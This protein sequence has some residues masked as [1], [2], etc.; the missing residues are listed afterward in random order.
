MTDFNCNGSFN[1]YTV[2][3]SSDGAL[4]GIISYMRGGEERLEDFFLEAGENMTFSSYIDGFN[5]GK[6]AERYMDV[7]F[8]FI[9]G[10]EK[11]EIFSVETQMAETFPGATC[12]IESDRY[13]LGV[14]LVWG[15]GLSYLEDKRNPDK[16]YDN[17]LNFYDTGRLVQ[18][19]YYG[20]GSYP[21]VTGEFMGNRW[22]Y[23]PVQGGDRG[24]NKSKLI[25]ARITGNSVYVKC[26]PR[27]WG[28]AGGYT[29]SYMENTYTL[30]GDIIRVDNRFTDFSGYT[31]GRSSQEVPAFYTISYLGNFWFYSGDKPW[32]D[33]ALDVRRD[34]FFWPEDWPKHTF[35]FAEGSDEK[36]CAWTDDGDYGVGLFTP[37]CDKMIGGRFSYNGTKD[38]KAGPTN[39]V[40]PCKFLTIECFKPIEYSYLI[41]AGRLDEI[42][43]NFKA[44][45]GEF[46]GKQFKGY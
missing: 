7:Q 13:K 12:F 23:N 16:T 2:K 39:Y 21:Y 18:Q 32:T 38:P 10:G 36:W 19:S 24:N 30:D 31:H 34:L 41:T 4:R 33:D 35:N 43:A 9:R 20:R 29:F 15:G 45:R 40:A 42:R 26:R 11:C 44:H 25:D 5:D 8:V 17:M 3:Y 14:E 28:H 6:V 1:R 22:S 27:D 46:A 37:D